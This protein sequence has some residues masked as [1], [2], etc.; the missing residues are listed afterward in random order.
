MEMRWSLLR[1]GPP[2]SCTLTFSSVPNA[3]KQGTRSSSP[4][5]STSTSELRLWGGDIQLEFC[6][7]L[8]H[9]HHVFFKWS[10][11]RPHE[12]FIPC[13]PMTT[14]MAGLYTGGVY[15]LGGM[16]FLPSNLCSGTNYRTMP[17]VDTKGVENMIDNQEQTSE[18]LFSTPRV[19]YRCLLGCWRHPVMHFW[20]T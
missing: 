6:Q 18:A 16:W 3:G 12:G 2:A 5:S 11:G 1:L 8:S 4:F 17:R 14:T 20:G 15:Q 7:P 9:A 19:T 13:M 10:Q